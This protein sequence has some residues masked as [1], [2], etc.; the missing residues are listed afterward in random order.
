MLNPHLPQGRT[1][2]WMYAL[3][4][5]CLHIACIFL[6]RSKADAV[7]SFFYVVAPGFAAVSCLYRARRSP[8]GVRRLWFLVSLA[9]ALW[10][11]GG[12][13]SAREEFFLHA[14]AQLGAISQIV[15]FL[16]GIPLLVAIAAPTESPW[17]GLFAAI[18]SIQ[19]LIMGL[20]TYS[21]I[22]NV[23]PLTGHSIEPVSVQVVVL[24]F[25]IENV[26]LACASTLRFRTSPAEE[27]NR[28]FYRSLAIYLW[29]YAAF[30]A[31]YNH[32]TI[33]HP[34]PMGFYN[35][36]QDFPF[37]VLSVL[38]LLPPLETRKS[39]R[40]SFGATLALLL[41]NAS[42][43][44]FPAA[45]LSLGIAIAR[46]HF[47][48]GAA[49]IAVS[50]G[51]YGIRSTLLQFRYHRSQIRAKEARDAMEVVAL[52]DQLTGVSNRRHFDRIFDS[53]WS[54]RSRQRAPLSLIL[55]D[56][57]HFKFVNDKFGHE[58]GDVCLRQ[59]AHALKASLQRESDTLARYGGEEFAALLP[60]TDAAG[61]Q[62]V[63]LRMQNI[64]R[65]LKLRNDT[66]A[67]NT[68]TISIGIATSDSPFVQ[69]TH[70]LFE[71]ADQ[72]LYRAKQ[73]GR[74]RIEQE[75]TQ[76]PQAD[77]PRKGNQRATDTVVLS[78]ATREG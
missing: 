52:T 14:N 23:I 60:G 29:V 70:S 39:I 59:V 71:A 57:D 58:E 4:F 75:P 28:H 33:T 34:G 20:A 64:I 69:T 48:S 51:A 27:V 56:I 72:A 63:A 35:L 32:V 55:V 54:R 6:L 62:A 65:G 30:A 11:L 38:A 44:L 24:A 74:N 17:S 10:T 78:D 37:L 1:R 25:N 7:A 49:A 21:L 18:D 15:Y 67:G 50:L 12:I 61:A 5:V 31:F 46:H 19:V 42:P 16:Y 36:L 26:V 8:A 66:P 43:F 47:R 9:L 13:L 40:S 3:A 76:T 2:L 73:N 45:V 77:L 22:F 41:D 68:V 53:E